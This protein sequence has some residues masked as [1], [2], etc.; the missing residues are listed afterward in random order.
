MRSKYVAYIGSYSY[1]G[2]AK[3]ITICDVDMEKGRFE[4]RTEVEVNN[5]SYVAVSPDK[6][7][8]YSIADEGIVSFR[9][10]DNGNLSKLNTR[11]IRGMRGCHLAVDK[12]GE[13]LMVSGYH[14][15]KSTLLSLEADGSVGPI[16]DGVYDQG[17]GSVAERTFRPHVSCSRMTDDQKFI[18][19][20]DLGIDQVKIFRFDKAD[21]KMRQVDTL[22]CELQ[23][24]PRHFRF[25]PD[26]N[27]L[28]LLYEL[29]NVVDVYHFSEGEKDSEVKLE[30][31]QTI[32][33]HNDKENNP[34]I[35]ACQ[36]RFSPDPDASHLFV[37]NAGINT[38]TIYDRDKATGLLSMKGSRP[39]AGEYPKDFCIFPDEKH[40]AVANNE[41]GTIT[42]FNID[43]EQGLLTMC[44]RELE[45]DEPN[46]ICMVE[47]RG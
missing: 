42:F 37:S 10:L 12:K 40:L 20:A 11:N 4:K 39:S 34:L 25:C 33:T 7:T 13:Y 6:R 41:S 1:T 28:Y 21:R 29:K 36:M 3:G 9:I 14:D 22:R 19:V 5:S 24:G 47:C 17:I 45:V 16:V 18:L 27:Y 46:S 23:S 31:L 38:I 26:R 32:S 43:Y 8:L 15:G 44:A 30:K 2:S 35:A